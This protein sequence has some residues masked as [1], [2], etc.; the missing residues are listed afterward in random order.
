M[1]KE[2]LLELEE[3]RKPNTSNAIQNFV[4]NRKGRWRVCHGLADAYLW[5]ME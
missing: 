3:M 5:S 1:E 2:I 4:I